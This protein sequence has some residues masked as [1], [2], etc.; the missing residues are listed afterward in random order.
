MAK[1][2]VIYARLSATTEE[3]VS[4]ARQ[5][6]SARKTAE[7]RGWEVV[8]EFTDDGVSAT[9]NRPEDR[10]GWRALLD[11]AEHYDVVVVWKVDRLSRRVLDFL[12]ADEA[13]RARGAAIVCVED[14]IDMSTGPGK[15]FATML[16]VFGQMEADAMSARILAARAHL[17]RDGRVTGGA[18]P[19]GWHH[20]PNPHGAGKILACDP[21]T[22]AWVR[23][24]AERA[25]RGDTVHSIRVWLD[26]EGAPLP[27]ASQKNRVRS[28]WSYGTVE[29]LLRNPV[30][31]G[32]RPHNPGRGRHDPAG[33][34]AAVLRDERGLPVVNESVAVVTTDEWRAIVEGLDRADSPQRA[35]RASRNATSPLLSRL[36]TCGECGDRTMARGVHSGRPVLTCKACFQIVA[37]PQLEALIEE[38]LLAE[39]G[40]EPIIEAVREAAADNSAALSDV[41]DAIR[42]AALAMAEDGAD[43]GALSARVVALR[44]E[45]TRLRQASPRE[46][47]WSYSGRS[48]RE[49]WA[50]AGDD[51]LERREVLASQ[52][53]SVTMRRGRGGRYLDKSRLT[54]EWQP[55]VATHFPTLEVRR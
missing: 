52:V 45:R 7:A 50:A 46:E 55:G 5:L 48:V 15:A 4:I 28:G 34:P 37:R 49:A 31:A 44:E 16:A 20:V 40:D 29:R 35:P 42:T 36:V 26:D 11:S 10:A 22:T 13:L 18:A 54:I 51:D 2:A 6:A 41:E 17:Q 12:H 24:M 14:P 53:A 3:S 33:G 32:M 1:R 9:A 47:S 27:A 39:R 23:G 25:L 8:G 19:Y 43:V 30:L 21:E 38:R